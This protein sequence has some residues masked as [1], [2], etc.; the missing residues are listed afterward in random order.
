MSI[1]DFFAPKAADEQEEKPFSPTSCRKLTSAL[2]AEAVEAKTRY[3]DDSEIM[4]DF[5]K[6]L[7]EMCKARCKKAAGGEHP[8]IKASAQF[9]PSRDRMSAYACV[10]PPENGGDALTREEFLEEM[11]YEGI[12]YG[13]LEDALQQELERGYL[14][15]FPV[16]RG[17]LP[18]AGKDGKVVELFRRCENMRLEAQNERQV[19]FDQEVQIQPIR[20]G[21]VICLIRL[22]VEGTNGSD[23]TGRVLP[24]P[25][26][27]SASI[28]QGE[29][30]AVREDGQALVA[31]VDGL[32]YT[33]DGRFC[34]QKQTVIDGDLNQLQMPLKASGNL[35]IQG[36]VD[37]GSVV[38]ALGDIMV[39]GRVGEARVTSVGG[40]IRIQQGVCGTQGK[41]FLSAARQVQAPLMERAEVN[42]GT[43]VI[44]E[45]ISNSTIHCDGTVYATAGRG[46]ITDSLIRAGDSIL[47]LRVGNLAGGRNRFSVGY[48]PHSP[49]SWNQLRAE[50]AETKST[51]K[52]LWN[53]IAD[54]RKKGTKIS[55]MEKSVLERLVE[56]RDLYIEKRE[57]LMT[58]LSILDQ[59]LDKKS[60]GRV[61]CEKLHP[62]LEVQIGR[63]TQE[64]T[65]LEE[66]C[67]I[68]V[69]EGRILLK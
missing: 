69:A 25:R 31:S 58:E 4:T 55:D 61:R 1:F 67:N 17:T 45:L 22:P 40:T 64:I 12:N 43:S 9:F 13:I 57:S 36:N 19:D 50:L 24:C 54:L 59:V 47:C 52:K 6:V 18:R 15:I 53:T 21:M 68:R 44:A 29:N 20:K 14:H 8:S 3:P 41:T 38:E 56:Q 5:V 39:K 62:I 2:D 65:T 48:P 27:G 63:L 51:I 35:Y 42:A 34:V 46:M 26:P 10:L 23:V 30:T 11:R 33:K 16:A 37:G 28:P 32:L 60:S 49:E 7:K 66:N